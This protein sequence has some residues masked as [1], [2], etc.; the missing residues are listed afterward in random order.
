[1]NTRKV[2]A[3]LLK[4]NATPTEWDLYHHSLWF[5]EPFKNGDLLARYK[6]SRH[7]IRQHLSRMV[8]KGLIVRHSYHTYIAAKPV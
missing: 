3:F 1:M 4:K 5:K 7:N 6:T 2:K 8:D